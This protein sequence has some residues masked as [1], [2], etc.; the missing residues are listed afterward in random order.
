MILIAIDPQ[1]E[2]CGLVIGETPGGNGALWP[3]IQAVCLCETNDLIKFPKEVFYDRPNHDQKY[4]VIEGQYVG[5]GRKGAISLAK[6]T[7]RIEGSLSAI[8]FEI[9]EAPV[10]GKTW[11]ADMFGQGYTR[12]QNKDLAMRLAKKELPWPYNLSEH[13]ADAVCMWLWGL[14]QLKQKRLLNGLG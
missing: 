6:V 13:E 12:K 14:D 7:G 2:Q 10:F 11:M 9:T 4:A 3:R 5:P 1:V 8:G